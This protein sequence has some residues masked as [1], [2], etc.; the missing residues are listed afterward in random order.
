LNAKSKTTKNELCFIKLMENDLWTTHRKCFIQKSYIFHC[1][2]K[3]KRVEEVVDRSTTLFSFIV[4]KLNILI[5]LIS[6]QKVSFSVS[7]PRIELIEEINYFP[8]IKKIQR[9]W[10][11]I[12][13][14][15]I[16]LLNIYI[17][18]S[19]LYVAYAVELL[20]PFSS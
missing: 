3:T 14:R 7:W 12:N 9:D 2:Y 6:K 1:N 19:R 17:D 5:K 18:S 13:A 8:L 16:L 10:W 15:A 11:L 20:C 4:K